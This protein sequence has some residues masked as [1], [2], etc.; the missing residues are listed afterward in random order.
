MSKLTIFMFEVSTFNYMAIKIVLEG[1]FHCNIFFES[2]VYANCSS[3]VDFSLSSHQNKWD[4]LSELMLYIVFILFLLIWHDENYLHFSYIIIKMII[5]VLTEL[6][7]MKAATMIKLLTMP[8]IA[9]AANIT[10]VTFQIESG[11]SG[12]V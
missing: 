5:C 10:D 6:F 11:K 4:N 12:C 7:L 9:T 8:K 3:L 1:I 2:A